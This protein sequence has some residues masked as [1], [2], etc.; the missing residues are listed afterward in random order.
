MYLQTLITVM[1]ID[2]YY[3][4]SDLMK[5]TD[6]FFC[7]Y[8]NLSQKIEIRTLKIIVRN[9]KRMRFFGRFVRNSI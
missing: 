8:F 7:F 6:E 9:N 2:S 3:R 1:K 4:L 5:I